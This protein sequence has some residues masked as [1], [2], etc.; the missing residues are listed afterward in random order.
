MWFL[1]SKAYED[2]KCVAEEAE[3]KVNITELLPNT[4]QR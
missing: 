4:E 3:I 1:N 2:I